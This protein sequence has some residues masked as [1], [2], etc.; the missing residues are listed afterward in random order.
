MVAAVLALTLALGA[1]AAAETAGQITVGGGDL[2]Q[3][4]L[5]DVPVQESV[6]A[7]P[8]IDDVVNLSSEELGAIPGV[9]TEFADGTFAHLQGA[10]RLSGEC[11]ITVPFDQET[12]DAAENLKSAEFSVLSCMADPVTGE[13]A[14]GCAEKCEDFLGLRFETKIDVGAK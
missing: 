10:L 9:P 8:A 1:C 11:E 3:D 12:L 14:P 4:G 5:P 7:W 2:N 13:P 6:L